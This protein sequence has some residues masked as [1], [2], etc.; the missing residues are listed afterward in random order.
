MGKNDKKDAKIKRQ[1]DKFMKSVEAFLKAKNGGKVP[2]EWGCSLMILETYFEQFCILRAEI[3]ELD[4]LVQQSRYGLQ[5]HPLLAAL[6]KVVIRLES[7]L[8]QTGLTFKEAAKLEVIEP[9]AEESALE[10]FM[11]NKVEKR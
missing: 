6:D 8:K 9:V 4:S 11:K 7:M 3:N 2:P 5:P 10:A 1:T